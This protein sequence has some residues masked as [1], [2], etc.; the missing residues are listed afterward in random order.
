LSKLAKIDPNF[1]EQYSL[2]ESLSVQAEEL[3]RTLRTYSEKVEYSPSRLVEVEER[4]DALN[5]LKR[6]YGGSIETGLGHPGKTAKDLSDI[7]NSEER[8]VELR[9]QEETL[10]HQIG[11]LASRLSM[12]RTGAAIK[13]GTNVETE[14]QDLRMEGAR[15]QVELTQEDDP[16]GCF[17]GERRL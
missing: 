5:R 12:A 4:L 16:E 8:L 11:D 6:K 14:M 15:F 17:V 1:Q 13:L 7:T 9:K 2:A 3:A 10:L